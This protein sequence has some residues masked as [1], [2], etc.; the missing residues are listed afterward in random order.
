[1]REIKKMKEEELI[2][3]EGKRVTLLWKNK[4]ISEKSE[5]ALFFIS[6]YCAGTSL[7]WLS[8]RGYAA[9]LYWPPEPHGRI[10]PAPDQCAPVGDVFMHGR[11]WNTKFFRRFS[12]CCIGVYHKFRNLNRPFLNIRFQA[13][14]SSDYRLVMYM[15]AMGKIWKAA[16]RGDSR[17]LYEL[18]NLE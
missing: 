9:P 1:M 17:F 10:L 16:I 4:A 14:L 8:R 5:I 7:S 6:V 13:K 3:I 2:A 12:H 15:Q 11:F 18:G